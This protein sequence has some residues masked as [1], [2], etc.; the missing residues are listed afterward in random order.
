MSG[1]MLSDKPRVSVNG[2]FVFVDVVKM[3][4]WYLGISGPRIKASI[5][6]LSSMMKILI[7]LLLAYYYHCLIGINYSLLNY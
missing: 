6:F 4:L 7:S 2:E 5:F 1:I 3:L